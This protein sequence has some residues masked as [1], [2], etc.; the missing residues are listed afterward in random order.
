MYDEG[1]GA[2]QNY[3]R[4]VKWYS[5]AAAQGLPEAQDNLAGLCK[6]VSVGC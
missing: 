6:Q 5:K 1:L 3:S 2:P 4:A